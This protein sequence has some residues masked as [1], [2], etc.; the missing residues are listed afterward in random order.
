MKFI[1]VDIKFK[2]NIN[3]WIEL[4]PCNRCVEQF[5]CQPQ[6]SGVSQNIFYI[7][8][9]DVQCKKSLVA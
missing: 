3:V 6:D 7:Q 2:F 4:F 9:Y 5:Y 8:K 1:V